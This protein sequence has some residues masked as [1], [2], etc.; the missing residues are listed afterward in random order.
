MCKAFFTSPFFFRKDRLRKRENRR[1]QRQARLERDQVMAGV[2]RSNS[3]PILNENDNSNWFLKEKPPEEMRKA[4][5]LTR[6]GGYEPFVVGK[7]IKRYSEELDR[8][9]GYLPS[10]A[11]RYV[12]PQGSSAE[13]K[14][15]SLP[16]QLSSRPEGPHAA[17]ERMVRLGMIPPRSHVVD[18]HYPVGYM[19]TPHP[20]AS[21][22]T[23]GGR[24][25]ERFHSTGDV[26]MPLEENKLWQMENSSNPPPFPLPKEDYNTEGATWYR[27]RS[28]DGPILVGS[29]SSYPRHGPQVYSNSQ[30]PNG[31]INRGDVSPIATSAIQ[32]EYHTGHTQDKIKRVQRVGVPI[33]PD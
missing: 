32:E 17:E 6:A 33:L 12:R 8:S 27:S 31:R 29:T 28:L 11:N 14:R 25:K 23:K 26:L 1:L 7:S 13:W 16:A 22:P 9:S 3:M 24:R 18:G 20:R 4:T 30:H 10:S 2:G 19:T 15:G 21:S 5:T